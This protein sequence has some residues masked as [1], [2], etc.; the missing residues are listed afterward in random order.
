MINRSHNAFKKSVTINHFIFKGLVIGLQ[1]CF[2]L[3]MI[4][5][6]ACLVLK[7]KMVKFAGV[8][9]QNILQRS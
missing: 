2:V 3:C 8:S 4:M 9:P 5:K 7:K 1:Q 6:I